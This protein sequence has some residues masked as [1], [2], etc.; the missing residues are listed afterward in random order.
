ME[1]G[2]FAAASRRLGVPKSTISKRVAQLEASLGARLIQRT[3]RSFTLTEVGRDFHEHARA[4]MIEAEAA[5]RVVRRRTVEPSGPVRLTVSV[6]VAQVYLSASIPKLVRAYP[7]IELFVD[8]TDRFVDIV[9]EGYDI[10]VRSHFAPLPPSGLVQR[11][12]SVEPFILVAAPSYLAGRD[13]I[14]TPT[15]LAA[16]RGLVSDRSARTWRL[17][18]P[19][20]RRI[21]VAPIPVMVANESTVLAGAAEAGL[22]I[23]VLPA[24]FCR[25]RLRAGSLVR[26]LPAW[27]AGRVTTTLLMPH[28]RGQLPAVRATAEFLITALADEGDAGPTR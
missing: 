12:V 24:S 17:F 21:D 25:A 20:G 1:H 23:A 10:A 28:R 27:D 9:Q 26:V 7:K 11:P 4:A 3:S 13:P 2:G 5:E 8:V 14:E 15:E 22:G 6:P 16:H 19:E 18:G